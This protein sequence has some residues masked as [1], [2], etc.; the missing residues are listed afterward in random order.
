MKVVCVRMG[1]DMYMRLLEM[2]GP[3][4]LSETVRELLEIAL[5]ALYAPP[6]RPR[7]GEE[8]GEEVEVLRGRW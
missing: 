1:E 4:T 5:A 2:A 6:C 8:G 7:E 3:K